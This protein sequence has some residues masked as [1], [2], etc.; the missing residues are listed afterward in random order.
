LKAV[1]LDLDGLI[2]DTE[3]LHQRAVNVLLRK[4]HVDYRFGTEEYGKCFVGIP[5]IKNVHYLKARFGLRGAP[6]AI[7]DERETIYESLI[8]ELAN[9]V[10]MPGVMHLLDTM[11]ARQIPLGVASGSPRH[12]VEIVLRGINIIDRFQ[13]I[14]AGNEVPKTKPAPDVYLRAA[15]KIGVAPADA[16]AL[17]DSATGIIAAKSAGL[18]AI[19]VPN[20]FTAH[21]DLSHADA[22]VK[23]LNEALR[24]L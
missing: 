5:V 10:V 12:Q 11:R 22:R 16:T 23:D 8:A 9:L 4:H 6:Q 17:E 13:A 18:R 15:E 19:A 2:V 1:I 20:R 3:P 14:V 24:L 21:Q 7:I